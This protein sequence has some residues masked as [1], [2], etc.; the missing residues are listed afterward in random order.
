MET[1]RKKNFVHSDFNYAN[2]NDKKVPRVWNVLNLS[3]LVF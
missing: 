3:V 1:N 2:H